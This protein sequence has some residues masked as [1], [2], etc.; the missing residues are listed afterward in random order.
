MGPEETG[1]CQ[2]RDQ[3]CP[4]PRV[5]CGPVRNSI[6]GCRHQQLSSCPGLSLRRRKAQSKGLSPMDVLSC[7]LGC[8]A[9]CLCPLAVR[10]QWEELRPCEPQL[11]A[12]PGLRAKTQ[13]NTNPKPKKL[14]CL[15]EHTVDFCNFRL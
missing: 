13:A 7:V 9:E 14:I 2:T 1:P 12:A 5:L 11:S 15:L 8:Q 6:P 3:L 4:I 10:G